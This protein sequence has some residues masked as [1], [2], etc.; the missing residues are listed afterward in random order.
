[1]PAMPKTPLLAKLGDQRDRHELQ[2]GERP[3][4]GADDDVEALPCGE[5]GSHF[6]HEFLRERERRLVR[7]ERG[8][9]ARKVREAGA[10]REEMLE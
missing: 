6:L 7:I 4:G 10:G 1:M 8:I 5:R 3:A 9:T 2:S